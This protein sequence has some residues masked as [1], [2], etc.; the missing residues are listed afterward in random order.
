MFLS[1]EMAGII[2]AERWEKRLTQI[3]TNTFLGTELNFYVCRLRFA[4]FTL[5]RC[6]PIFDSH[7]HDD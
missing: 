1:F 2:S 6:K 5:I 3:R 7:D 4:S